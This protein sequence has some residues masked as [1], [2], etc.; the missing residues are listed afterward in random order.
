[1]KTKRAY[2]TRYNHIAT[3]GIKWGDTLQSD[4]TWHQLYNWTCN[5]VRDVGM[6]GG[7]ALTVAWAKANLDRLRKMRIGA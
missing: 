7:G 1:M 6:Y 2:E 3:H 4:Y 5:V